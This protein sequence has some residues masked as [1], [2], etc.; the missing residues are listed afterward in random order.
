MKTFSEFS[1]SPLLKTNLARHGFT[2]P[3][4]IQSMAIEP[5]LAGQN[6]VATAQTGTGKTLAFVLPLIQALTARGAPTGIH[7]VILS[8]TR[9]LA[10]QI[11]ETFVKMAAG[12]GV[13]AAVVVGGLSEKSQLQ[14]IRKGAQVLIATAGRLHDFLSR[15][16]I[17][18]GASDILVLDEADRMLDMGFLPTIQRILAALPRVRQTLFFSATIESSVKH[19]V[20][21]HAPN[22]V[23]IEIDPITKPAER[24]DLHL[25]EVEQ[26]GK[27]DLLHSMLKRQEGAFLVFARTKR[28]AE[29]LARRLAD[30]GVNTAAIHGD[31]SQ[32]QRTQ[33]LRGFQAG[34]YRVLVAT[35]IAARGIHVDGISH[36]VNYDLPQVPE[37][38]I[39]R[40]G[41]TGRAG[42]RGTASTFGTRSERS[43]IAQIERTIAMRLV[44]CNDTGEISTDQADAP[45]RPQ[46]RRW[47]SFGPA[48]G[49]HRQVHTMH[50]RRA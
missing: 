22:A 44:R 49:G 16:L 33:A 8:P 23:R 5:A 50:A 3:T 35:D 34:R 10:L 31:R 41:R 42:A 9:E 19:L 45:E 39:H 18:L 40:V 1:L 6:L 43:A 32:N 21:M 28:G 14:A 47:R 17:D 26:E 36:V 13:R 30:Q 38:F 15:G 11:N 46:A 29:R 20:E 24:V 37:D 2:V 27:L 7:A 48:R 4:P 12:S 25:Y